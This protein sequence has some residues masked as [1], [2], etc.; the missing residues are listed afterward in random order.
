[1]LE[2]RRTG[3]VLVG[4][5][6]RIYA[7]GGMNDDELLM[8]AEY[9][10]PRVDQWDIFPSMST[11]RFGAAAA[12]LGHCLYIVGGEDEDEHEDNIPLRSTERI[13]PL[14]HQWEVLPCMATA[15]SRRALSSFALFG[16]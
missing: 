7:C 8:S 6:G 3:E 9:Y 5:G 10:N 12:A 11:R 15:R 4:F 1:M 13:N 16:E 14:S 2:H